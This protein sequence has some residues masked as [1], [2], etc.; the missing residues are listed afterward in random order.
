MTSEATRQHYQLAT[1]KG[2]QGNAG[3]SKTTPRYAKGGA[4]KPMKGFA[5]KKTSV[6]G[7]ARSFKSGTN[8]SGLRGD[9]K[10]TSVTQR[11][12][13]RGFGVQRP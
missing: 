4:V 8:N 12:R 10:F 7:S 2:L 6:A 1:G 11:Q 13:P 9:D 5:G 3:G